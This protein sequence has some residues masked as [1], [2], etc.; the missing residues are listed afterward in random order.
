[1]GNLFNQ[2]HRKVYGEKSVEFSILSVGALIFGQSFS[3]KGGFSVPLII[4]G[5]IFFIIGIIASYFFLKG[6]KGGE[7]Q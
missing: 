6:I 2:T 1:M 3:E 7:K 4:A 5:V